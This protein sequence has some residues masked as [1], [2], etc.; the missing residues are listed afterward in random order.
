VGNCGSRLPIRLGEN[1]EEDLLVVKPYESP[2]QQGV[3]GGI[4]TG[5]SLFSL[6]R[7]SLAFP[8]FETV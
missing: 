8:R 6:T 3:A 1:I 2:F 4:K 7:D 5:R